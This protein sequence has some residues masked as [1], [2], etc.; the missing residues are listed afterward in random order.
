MPSPK[1]GG[2]SIGECISIGESISEWRLQWF[3]VIIAIEG[4]IA[5]VLSLFRQAML[6]W[7][8][9]MPW[10]RPIG[11]TQ[12]TSPVKLAM[13]E[14]NVAAAFAIR[15][16]SID[17]LALRHAYGRATHFADTCVFMY[18]AW[19]GGPQGFLNA[20]KEALEKDPW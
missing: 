9:T 5:A 4:R 17:H 3:R 2:Q 13:R 7:T 15:W 12:A 8:M 18:N 11:R 1:A 10:L 16:C 6:S 19:R 14:R 20:L